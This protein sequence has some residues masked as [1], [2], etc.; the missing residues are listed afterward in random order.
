LNLRNLSLPKRALYQTELHPGPLENS[1]FPAKLPGRAAPM[2]VC[3]ANHAARDFSCEHRE[4]GNPMREISDVCPFLLDAIELE[5]VAIGFAAVDAR[6]RPQIFA[7]I[8][9]VAIAIT[10]VVLP[11]TAPM[12]ALILVVVLEASPCVTRPTI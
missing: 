8:L 11:D 9:P 10:R 3:A 12:F 6:M 1:F 2:A 7:D 4:R 5:H